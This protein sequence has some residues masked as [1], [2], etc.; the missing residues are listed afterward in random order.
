[1]DSG[2]AALMGSLIGSVS[3]IATVLVTEH[4]KGKRERLLSEIRKKT[5]IKILSNSKFHY[6]RLP[7]LAE[8]VGLGDEETI[9]LLLE[10]G[11]RKNR[12]KDS[13]QWGLISRNPWPDE[14]DAAN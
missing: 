10:I 12:A 7:T 1:M 3:G 5:L 2:L 6:R 14:E 13:D 9:A 8:S 11:A 4:L